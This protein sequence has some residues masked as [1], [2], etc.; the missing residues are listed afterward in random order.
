MN[1]DE[2]E[3]KL[4]ELLPAKY[5]LI[6]PPFTK[7][8]TFTYETSLDNDE[9]FHLLITIPNIL[10]VKYNYGSTDM[11][12]TYLGYQNLEHLLE[13]YKKLLTNNKSI[14]NL[15][16]TEIMNKLKIKFFVEENIEFFS[17]DF[18]YLNLNFYNKTINN[19]YFIV[20]KNDMK[21]ILTKEQILFYMQKN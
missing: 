6:D 20:L 9:I 3:N 18:L 1:K 10:T 8:K 21:K 2:I 12:N 13:K 15:E 19:E 4:K 11:V 5:K 17:E 16:P 14:F 7:K